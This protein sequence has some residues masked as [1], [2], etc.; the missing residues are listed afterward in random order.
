MLFRS[1]YNNSKKYKFVHGR[2][3]EAGLDYLKW[4]GSL[5]YGSDYGFKKDSK[6]YNKPTPQA[7]SAQ[8]IL[9]LYNWWKSREN[10]P[11][12]Y[13]LYNK[14]KDGKSYYK[15]IDKLEKQYDKEDTKMLIELIK[16]R[17]HL[18]C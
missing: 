2:S 11:N 12:I 6:D 3:Q 9:E 16:I 14:E 17:N 18:W 5:T 8:K 4:A 10:R 15:K 7:T 1:K 13:D